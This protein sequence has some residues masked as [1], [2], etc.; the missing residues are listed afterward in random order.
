MFRSGVKDFTLGLELCKDV[1]MRLRAVPASSQSLLTK[2]RDWVLPESFWAKNLFW[3]GCIR[4][5]L[6]I[7]SLF[8]DIGLQRECESASYRSTMFIQCPK[9]LWISVPLS[10][11]EYRVGF[12]YRFTNM[13][14]SVPSGAVLVESGRPERRTILCYELSCGPLS[15]GLELCTDP[16]WDIS[17]DI[18]SW[19]KQPKYRRYKKQTSQQQC[20]ERPL[21]RVPLDI[22]IHQKNWKAIFLKKN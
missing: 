7:H 15:F 2:L 19:F 3:E 6:L 8:S 17:V 22:C 1:F 10:V 21:A 9:Q 18:A 14:E 11:Q 4:G 20:S 13:P 12:H 16:A 5:V